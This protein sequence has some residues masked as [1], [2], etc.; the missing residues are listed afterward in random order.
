LVADEP[1]S[2]LD[3]SVQAQILNLLKEIKQKRRLSILFVTHDFAVARFLCDEIAV[4]YKGRIV[5]KAPAAELFARPLHPYTQALLAAVPQVG[6]VLPAPVAAQDSDRASYAC[7]FA[8]RCPQVTEACKSGGIQLKQITPHHV[9]ACV[10]T[11]EKP[12]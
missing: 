10:L 1:V 9:C 11:K 5:E 2:A 3:V 8:S 4:M 12:S 7:P 6:G